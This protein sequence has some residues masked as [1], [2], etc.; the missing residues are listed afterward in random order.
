MSLFR[1]LHEWR[2][3]RRDD[4]RR[5]AERKAQAQG[6][7][8]DEVREAGERAEREPHGPGSLSVWER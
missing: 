8:T 5:E 3:S 6:K 1:R 7:L 4:V 2:E